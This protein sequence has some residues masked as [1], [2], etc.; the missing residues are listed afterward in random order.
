MKENA[1]TI[2]FI[3]AARYRF[4][5]PEI[6]I[7]KV[8]P[9]AELEGNIKYQKLRKDEYDRIQKFHKSIQSKFLDHTK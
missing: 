3:W 2:S 1:K 4:R 9:K 7:D 5:F 8:T 6:Q